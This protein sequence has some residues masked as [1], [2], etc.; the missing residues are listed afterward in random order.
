M[1]KYGSPNSTR[2]ESFH[3]H[4]LANILQMETNGFEGIDLFD[5]CFGIELKCKLLHKGYQTGIAA[6]DHQFKSYPQQNTGKELFWAFLYYKLS[7][8]VKEILD[9]PDSYLTER[10]VYFQPWPFVQQFPPNRTKLETW[11]YIRRKAVLSQEYEIIKIENN[12]FYFPRGCSLIQRL[13]PE[14]LSEI[15][16]I[17]F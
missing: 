13:K 5:D 16:Q 17:P 9:N 7:K 15:S 6:A 1:T 3:R 11:R 10:K 4:W 8:P 2:L 14:N 12:E